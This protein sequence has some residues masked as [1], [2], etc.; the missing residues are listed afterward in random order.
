MRALEKFSVVDPDH[1]SDP[2]PVI[3]GALI[4]IL[5]TKKARISC[6]Q[7]SLETENRKNERKMERNKKEGNQVFCII[8][9]LRGA[10]KK[11]FY[12]SA[13]GH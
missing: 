10:V 12:F 2:G 11:V 8:R 7:T 1:F 4:W 13:P 5:I 9:L 6:P 3:I